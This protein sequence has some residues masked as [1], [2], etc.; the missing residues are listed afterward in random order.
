MVFYCAL[1]RLA[2]I[3]MPVSE[4]LIQLT[5]SLYERDFFREGHNLETL[6]LSGMPLRQIVAV[7]QTGF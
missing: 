3:P 4:S 6:G 5:S 2:G 7:T 1:G